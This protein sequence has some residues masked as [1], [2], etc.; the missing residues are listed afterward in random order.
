[1]NYVAKDRYHAHREAR[2]ADDDKP[3]VIISST[4]AP[5]QV[6]IEIKHGGKR[7]TL[8]QL[9][10]ALKQ[11]LAVNYLKP[12][13]RRHGILV[14]THRRDRK[15]VDPKSRK[16]MTFENLIKRL[17]SIAATLDHNAF[18]AIGVKCVGINAWRPIAAVETKKVPARRI[19]RSR[20]R[21]L[22]ARKTHKHSS[23][24]KR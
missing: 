13:T 2:V 8:R 9:E 14:V 10:A 24:S 12:S 5:V 16:P 3:D 19:T 20:S 22:S 17:S 6:A 4:S 7:W 15:W 21:S 1:M 18:G 23:R 11:Q